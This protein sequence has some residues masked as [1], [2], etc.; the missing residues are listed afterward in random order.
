MCLL[1][2]VRTKIAAG[3]R[4]VIPAAY[5]DALGLREGDQVI[6]RL[7]DGEVRLLSPR[8]AI[9]RAQ[10]IVARYVAAD[11]SLAD[12]LIAERRREAVDE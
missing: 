3:G 8:S 7:E 12:E 5:R 11:R 4:V 6:L 9:E 10:A 1:Q 2:S